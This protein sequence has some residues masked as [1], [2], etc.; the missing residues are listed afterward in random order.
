MLALSAPCFRDEAA[1]YAKLEQVLWP[2]GPICPRCGGMDRI[3]IVGGTTARIG[4]KRC[5][6]CKRQFSVTIGTVFESHHVPLNKWLRAVCLIAS[7][8]KGGSSR[9]LHRTLGVTYKTAWLMARRLREAMRECKF[10]G[11]F[12]GANKIVEAHETYV[13]A[14]AKN[15]KNH[16]PPKE[17][18]AQP[19]KPEIKVGSRHGVEAA[20]LPRS[21]DRTFGPILNPKELSDRYDGRISVARLASWRSLGYA[22]P[23]PGFRIAGRI[24]YTVEDVEVWEKSA[25]FRGLVADQFRKINNRLQ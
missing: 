6:Q 18:A 1:A 8:K 20:T 15:R 19:V 16:V 7:G 2:N 17:V 5:L 12:G 21:T 9:Q 10:F 25:T 23:R 11:G 14:K 24:Y 13:C 3:T 4:L 22:G